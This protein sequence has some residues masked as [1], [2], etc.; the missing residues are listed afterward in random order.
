VDFLAAGL[1]SPKV[2]TQ[3]PIRVGLRSPKVQTQRPIRVGLRSPSPNPKSD[4]KLDLD[5]KSKSNYLN[6]LPSPSPSR[7]DFVRF[8]DLQHRK[9]TQTGGW[10][11]GERGACCNRGAEPG[12]G[13][14]AGVPAAFRRPADVATSTHCARVAVVS[15]PPPPPAPRMPLGSG[16]V[17][18]PIGGP[19]PR[20]ALK[21][22]RRPGEQ[23]M[24]KIPPRFYKI[25]GA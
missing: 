9:R 20:G 21:W 25:G 5:F 22:H 18:P 4:N 15:V 8:L 11:G 6:G 2:Q 13:R 23:R 3:S 17:S 16:L 12:G 24:R 14:R 7:L 1:R 19:I 10:E